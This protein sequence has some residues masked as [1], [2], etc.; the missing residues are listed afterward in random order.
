MSRPRRDPVI[1][2]IVWLTDE[3]DAYYGRPFKVTLITTTP[4][5][6]RLLSY[7]IES[8][9][10]T[11]IVHNLSRPQIALKAPGVEM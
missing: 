7:T 6:T 11:M 1:G 3:T 8:S 2:S 9:D 5:S 10:G 4:F